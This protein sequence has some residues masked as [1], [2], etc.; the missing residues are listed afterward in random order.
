MISP[1]PSALRMA[2]PS[3]SCPSFFAVSVSRSASWSNS[4]L[5][6][7]ASVNSASRLILDAAGRSAVA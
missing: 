1:R 6:G 7:L 5:A 2:L 3:T 4:S